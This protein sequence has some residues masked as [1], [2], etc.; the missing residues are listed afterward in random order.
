MKI[1]V[2]GAQGMLGTD[3]VKVLSSTKTVVGTDIEDFDITR[4]EGTIEAV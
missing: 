3:L 1:L 2:V 4:Q